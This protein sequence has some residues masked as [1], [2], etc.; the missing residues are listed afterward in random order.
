VASLW[1][2]SSGFGVRLG[3]GR[4][5]ARKLMDW[6]GSGSKQF[7]ARGCKRVTTSRKEL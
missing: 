6:A 7:S 5:R 2:G 4:L 3:L 1:V